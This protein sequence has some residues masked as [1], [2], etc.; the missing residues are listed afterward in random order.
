MLPFLRGLYARHHGLL[1][2]KP[3]SACEEKCVPPEVQEVLPDIDA[4]LSPR[5]RLFG[6]AAPPTSG[7]APEMKSEDVQCEID[8]RLWSAEIDRATL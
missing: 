5:V 1:T 3:P 8:Y 2:R 4:A 6:E 7:R